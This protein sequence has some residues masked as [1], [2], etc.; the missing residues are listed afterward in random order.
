MKKILLLLPAGFLLGGCMA[1]VSPAG[2]VE[3]A[4]L[5]PAVEVVPAVTTVVDVTP[6][7]TGIIVPRPPRYA[8]AVHPRP[9]HFRPAPAP[10]PLVRPVPPAR[11]HHA[12]GHQARP[13]AK[14]NAP[15][16]P[17]MVSGR[18]QIVRPARQQHDNHV[19]HSDGPGHR[20]T[21]GPARAA[22]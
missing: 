17:N 16:K 10:R 6:V 1:T 21:V 12:T 20:Q 9:H 22:K 8:H 14:P 15:V 2:E 3:T 7:Y 4:Y 19:S 18:P 11:P 5:A 13:L